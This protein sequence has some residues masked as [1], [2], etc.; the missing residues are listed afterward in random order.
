MKYS[1]IKE[2]ER[3]LQGGKMKIFLVIALIILGGC[4]PRFWQALDEG[5]KDYQAKQE[6]YEK[7]RRAERQVQALE[8][9]EGELRT[10][11]RNIRY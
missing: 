4:N 7:E 3:Q 10:L 5:V 8:G 11:N 2:R 1:I 9:I 6:E